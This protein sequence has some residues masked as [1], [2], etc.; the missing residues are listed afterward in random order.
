MRIRLTGSE[1]RELCLRFGLEGIGNRGEQRAAWA[2]PQA[3]PF[4]R[5]VLLTFGDVLLWEHEDTKRDRW[6]EREK[7]RRRERQAGGGAK[8]GGRR[9][10]ER[11]GCTGGL[12]SSGYPPEAAIM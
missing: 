1:E 4:L 3:A 7:E 6:T 5:C 2:N 8:G 11:G 10:R 9:E 12:E